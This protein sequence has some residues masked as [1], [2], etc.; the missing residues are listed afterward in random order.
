MSEDRDAASI[1]KD[2]VDRARMGD[3]QGFGELYERY[4]TTI[5]RYVRSRVA[6][7]A[8]AE[9]ITEEVFLKS[10]EAIDR[11]KDRGHA[12]SSY[13]YRVAKNLL[14][15]HY[16]KLEDVISLDEVETRNSGE[17][18]DEHVIGREEQERIEIAIKSLSEDYQE[19][20]RL[21]ILMDLQ[22]PETA[23]WMGRSEGAVRVL[24][25]RAL[26]TLR[27]RLTENGE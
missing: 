24:L 25:H 20:L 4:A 19:V 1:D 10:F 11:Y 12:Y 15:D 2:L 9:D 16:R 14:A 26:K 22:T 27:D 5:Y 6:G 13:L 3:N 17:M 18:L 21:R 23:E 7:E 8:A